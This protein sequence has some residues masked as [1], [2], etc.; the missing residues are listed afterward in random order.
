MNRKLILASLAAAGMLATPLAGLPARAAAPAQALTA[1]D[2]DKIVLDKSDPTAITFLHRYSGGQITAVLEIVN[3]F[4]ANNPY[5]INVKLER[6]DG[7]YDDLYNKINAGLQGGKTPNIAQAYQNQASFYRGTADAV[8]DLTPYIQSKKYGLKAAEV[9][10]YYPIFLESDK[11]PQFPGEVL[12]WPTSRSIAVLYSNLDWLKKLGA[13]AP[14][15]TLK[16]FEALACK[17]TDG[18]AGKYGYIWRG[19][20]SDFAAFVFANG[21]SIMKP[22]ASAYDFNS[23]AAVEALTMLQRMFRNGCAVQL[24]SAERNGEQ[25]RF[26]AQTVLFVTAS[27]TG[28]PYYA[29]TIAKAPAKFE[30][31]MGMFP[32]ANPAKPKVN[33]YG[34]SWSVFAGTPEEQLA[35]WLFLKHFTEPKNIAA[36]AK[37]SN[38]IAVRKSAAPIAIKDVNASL[39]KTFPNAAAGY[40]SLYDM[41]KYGAVEAPVAGYDP[42]R[43]IISELVV[44]VAIKG[45]GDP[46]AKLDAAVAKANDILAE[47][48]PE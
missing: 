14:P 7:G 41:A 5:G 35:S 21:G 26:A 22:D 37:A 32:Q 4:N 1:A 28:L 42:V 24:P 44:E 30:W 8:I 25:T 13:K 3:D 23:P 33:L 36:W 45:Q 19:D 17:A 12:G 9:A 11:N 29:S 20:A 18:P 38:Y 48:A 6:V 47:N 27:S 2:V 46:K 15:A 40:A 10:D 31:T 34:A 43:K 39:G 16:D